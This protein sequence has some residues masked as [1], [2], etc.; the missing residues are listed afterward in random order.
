MTENKLYAIETEALSLCYPEGTEALQPTDL[1]IA[2]G[3]LVF[4]TGPSG[5]GKTSLLQ[6][7]M[8]MRRPTGGALHVLGHDMSKVQRRELRHLR[9]T[10][11]PVFQDFRLVPGRTALE[12]IVAGCRFLPGGPPDCRSAALAALDHVGLA[13]KA[14]AFIEHLSWGE[15]QRVSIARAVAR[16]P[17]LILADEPTGNLDR[18]NAQNI[19]NLLTSFRNRETTVLVTTH[20]THL[21]EKCNPDAV[22]AISDGVIRRSDTVFQEGWDR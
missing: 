10:I 22:Y 3:T 19:L 13:G 18:E 14:Q 16:Q 1:T 9:Q 15:R 12:N 5:S 2:T 17:R 20:A 11:G 4:F 6:L 21:I 8:G 7:L